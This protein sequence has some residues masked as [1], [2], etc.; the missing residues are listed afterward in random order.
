MMQDK[1]FDRL[2]YQKGAIKSYC[3]V[4]SYEVMFSSAFFCLLADYAKTA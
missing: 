2:W 3:F 1:M 4:I